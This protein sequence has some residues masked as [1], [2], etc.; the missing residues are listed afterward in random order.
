MLFDSALGW[1]SVAIAATATV[2]LAATIVAVSQ[3]L[4]RRR[5]EV[6]IAGRSPDIS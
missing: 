2:V 3:T 1:R 6:S 4:R 5:P